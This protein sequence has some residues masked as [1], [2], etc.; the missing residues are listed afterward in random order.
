MYYRTVY[1]TVT[2]CKEDL[3]WRRHL[4]PS[5]WCNGVL[6]ICYHDSLASQSSPVRVDHVLHRYVCVCV[7]KHGQLTTTDY[8]HRIC[9][10]KPL[11]NIDFTTKSFSY[12]HYS[13]AEL[14]KCAF[15]YTKYAQGWILR[16][17]QYFVSKWGQLS[18]FLNQR[19]IFFSKWNPFILTFHLEN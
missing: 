12:E 5:W 7:N 9:C 19:V 18:K 4:V 10:C 6:Q 15:G 14:S 8:T 17:D 13:F 2:R 11:I 3:T 1:R 16:C